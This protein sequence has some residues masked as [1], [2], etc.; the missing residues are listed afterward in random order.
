MGGILLQNVLW[1]IYNLPENI[2]K[3]HQMLQ[4]TCKESDTSLIKVL[5]GLKNKHFQYTSIMTFITE[6]FL[7]QRG[8]RF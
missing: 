3:R 8:K 5:C 6:L 1:N 4:S 2:N 7:M